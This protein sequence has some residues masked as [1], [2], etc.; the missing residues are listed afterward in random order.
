MKNISYLTANIIMITLIGVT[1]NVNGAEIEGIRF[2]NR[3][4]T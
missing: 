2:E 1:P 3:Y 4:E